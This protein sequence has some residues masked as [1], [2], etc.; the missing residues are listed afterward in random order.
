MIIFKLLSCLKGCCYW[1]E[2]KKQHARIHDSVLVLVPDA[3]P[4]FCNQCIIH[5]GDYLN[6]VSVKKGIIMHSHFSLEQTDMVK[7]LYGNDV[8]VVRLSEKRINDLH[9]FY[10]IDRFHPFV[11]FADTKH[12]IYNPSISIIEKSH[13]SVEELVC[14]GIYNL[15]AISESSL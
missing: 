2:L 5:L 12:P 9:K 13:I 1:K 10:L 11:I 8:T 6:K 4:L 15:R 3:D 14:L 7:K